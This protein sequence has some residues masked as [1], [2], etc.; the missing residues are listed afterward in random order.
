MLT[1]DNA[2]D[3]VIASLVLG[4]LGVFPN[5]TEFNAVGGRDIVEFAVRG[6]G[7]ARYPVAVAGLDVPVGNPPVVREFISSGMR[8][9]GT[10]TVSVLFSNRDVFNVGEI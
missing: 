6:V 10:T 1:P 8:K 7:G 9:P 4:V 5:L 2:S 3:G